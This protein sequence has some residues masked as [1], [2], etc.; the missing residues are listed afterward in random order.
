[1]SIFNDGH[2][3]GLLGGVRTQFATW[4]YAMQW[5][6]RPKRAL[7]VTIHGAAFESEA[8]NARNVLAVEDIKDEVF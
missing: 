7:K 6:L 2:K 8:K 5:L 1:M 3:I 4:F